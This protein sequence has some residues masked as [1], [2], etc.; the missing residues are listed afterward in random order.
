MSPAVVSAP[1]V[2]PQLAAGCA[3]L[4]VRSRAHSDRVVIVGLFTTVRGAGEFAIGL[5]EGGAVLELRVEHRNEGRWKPAW[6]WSA[7]EGAR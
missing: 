4:R 2:V 7:P 3:R 6:G 5:V 1:V